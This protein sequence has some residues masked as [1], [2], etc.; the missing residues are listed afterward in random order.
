MTWSP[1]D[2]P[3]LDGRTAVVTG[4]NGGLGLETTRELARKGARVLMAVRD[5]DKAV[6]AQA[7]IVAEVPGAELELVPCDLSSLNSV[8]AAAEDIAGRAPSIDLL[9]ANAGIMGTTEQRSADGFELQLAVNHLGHFALIGRLL[10]AVLAAAA[11]RIVTTTSVARFGGRAVDPANLNL[12]GRYDPWRAYG[13]SKLANAHFANELHRRLEAAGSPAASLLAHP[14][15]T[16]TDLQAR[17]AADSGGVVAR[18]GL[19][20]ARTTGMRPLAGALP[21]LRAGTDPS[22]ESGQLY[23][24]LFVTH[25]PPVR[26]PQ[27]P[28]DRDRSAGAD[29]WLASEEA[30]GVRIDVAGAAAGR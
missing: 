24:P 1:D 28:G 15:F 17:S 23:A 9:F 27:L 8:R 10:P 21:Q 5:H 14:G 22:A 29:L 11:G 6:A 18:L 4:A 7:A 12:V 13:R 16:D 26:R 3:R 30:T 19:F 25:G 20:A 2:I